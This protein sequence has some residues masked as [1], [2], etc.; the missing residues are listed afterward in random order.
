[1]SLIGETVKIRREE[2]GLDQLQLGQ[3]VGV[4]Q[5]TVSRWETG[6]AVP[7]PNRLPVLAEVLGLDPEYVHRMAGYLPVERTSPAAD[8]VHDLYARAAELSDDELL[9]LL[10]RI[11]Q[12][13]RKRKGLVPPGTS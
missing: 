11:W 2:L 9:L 10:D 4:G 6:V 3:R 12:E 1:V 8:L 5:Q 13:Y 7:K